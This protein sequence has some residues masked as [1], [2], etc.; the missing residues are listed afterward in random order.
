MRLFRLGER[1]SQCWAPSGGVLSGWVTLQSSLI[2]CSCDEQRAAPACICVHYFQLADSKRWMTTYKQRTKGHGP[3]PA[4]SCPL[5]FWRPIEQLA[6][7]RWHGDWLPGILH[8]N[9]LTSALPP[10]RNLKYF[11]RSLFSSYSLPVNNCRSRKEF[12]LHKCQQTFLTFSQ[13]PRKLR[14]R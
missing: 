3:A 10:T 9:A 8:R 6:C 13:S 11:Y 5:A 1:T 2:K 4:S 7:R 14:T 12:L